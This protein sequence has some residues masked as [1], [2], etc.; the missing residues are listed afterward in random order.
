M[1]S[2]AA[3]GPHRWDSIHTWIIGVGTGNSFFQR[4]NNWYSQGG[5]ITSWPGFIASM[6][7]LALIF[8]VVI[9]PTR[10]LH[11]IVTVLA[12]IAIGSAVL[13]FVFGF[14]LHQRDFA[15]NLPRETGVTYAQL[16]KAAQ[17]KDVKDKLTGQGVDVV[18]N[19]PDE[20]TSIIRAEVDKWKRVA[21]EAGIQLD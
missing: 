4:A 17:A 13:L 9:Q 19:T 11:R 10:R 12:G 2:S 14:F 21:K 16:V 18:A 6:V 3:N 5:V 15:A 7:V 1:P 8:W 20:F